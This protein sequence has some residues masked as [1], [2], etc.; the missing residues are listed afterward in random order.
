MHLELLIP[1]G[2]TGFLA[3]IIAV[4]LGALYDHR[5][6]QRPDRTSGPSLRR[7]GRRTPR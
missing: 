7:M 4:I 1:I 5:D 6:S 3:F 2:I